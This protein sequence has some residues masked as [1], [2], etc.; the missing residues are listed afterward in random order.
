MPEYLKRLLMKQRYLEEHE[1]DENAGGAGGAGDDD[2]DDDD[3]QDPAPADTV[4]VGE[5]ED[6]S[7]VL[8][9]EE[10][11]PDPNAEPVTETT[12]AEDELA[13][14]RE[15]RRQERQDRKNRQKEREESLRREL[16]QERRARQEQ[17]KRLAALEGNDQG[18]R[19]AQV[20][21]EIK[22][23]AISYNDWK[24]KLE[25]AHE[26]HDGKL[27]AAA[28]EKMFQ[29]RERF[30]N[31]KH[32]RQSLEDANKRKPAPADPAVADHAQQFLKD[33]SWYKSDSN[34]VD[35]SVLKTIDNALAAEGRN[36]ADPEYWQELRARV[37][38]YLP[39]RVAGGK[40]STS[41]TTSGGKATPQRQAKSVVS[42]GSGTQSA[43]SKKT[44]TLSADRVKAIK[45]A[46]MWDDPKQRNEMI[47]SY[48]QYD[49]KNKG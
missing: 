2:D 25:E 5:Q 31:L 14:K 47:Q 8:E 27:A 44:I 20:D 49:K 26:Q 43:P 34:D 17:D 36:A 1:D 29:A 28:T 15:A 45:E 6:G 3:D 32:T 37:K 11:T 39:H 46:G 40:V 13:A 21:E 9:L 18:R 22:S 24:A 30:E 48:Q 16:A 42:G 7:V 33:H 23:L 41:D 35:S 38:K 4:K 10:G 12:D 19:I